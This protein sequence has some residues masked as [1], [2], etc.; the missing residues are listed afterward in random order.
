[1]ITSLAKANEWLRFLPFIGFAMLFAKLTASGLW[2]TYKWF[3]V[4]LAVETLRILLSLLVS[5]SS[6]LYA[7]LYFIFEPLTWLLS[8]LAVLEVYGMVLKSHP[9]IA[10][11]GRKSIFIAMVLSLVISAILSSAG[12]QHPEVQYRLLHSLLLLSRFVTGSLLFFLLAITAFLVWFPIVL[13]RNTVL[14]CC[15]FAVFFLVKTAAFVWVTIF[16]L[17]VRLAANSSLFIVVALCTGTW[18]IWLN[19]KGEAVPVTVGH[20]WNRD[21][22]Q[23]LLAQL[24]SINTALLNSAKD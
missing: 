12:T 11:W 9:A 6:N 3:S 10:N 19:Q 7:W 21:E 1:M 13:K 16:G 8:M 4:Y 18:L 15:L 22:E 5:D 24:N 23:R 17:G 2:R 14:H 20:S